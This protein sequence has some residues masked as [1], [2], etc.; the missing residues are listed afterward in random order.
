M[1]YNSVVYELLQAVR[2][3][4]RERQQR[5]VAE[6][7]STLLATKLF[8]PPVRPGLVFR[9]RLLDKLNAV[10]GSALTLVSAPAG[11][12]KTTLISEWVNSRH[13]PLPTAWLSL[14]ESE[15]D[16]ARFWEYFVAALRTVRPN[17]GEATLRQLHSL[18]P[19]PIESALAPLVNDLAVIVEDLVMVLD[20]YHFIE[21]AP[22]NRGVSFFLDH[23]PPRM[24]LII[25]TRVDPPLPLARLRGK[26]VLCEIGADDLRFTFEEAAVLLRTPLGPELSPG[27]LRAINARAEGWAVGLKMAGLSLGKRRDVKESVAAFAGSQRYVM[28]YLMDEV[29]RQQSAEIRSFLLMTSIL[30]RLCAP[31]CAAVTGRDDSQELLEELERSHLFVVPL[32][33]SRK[34]YRYEHL[35]A[36]LLKHRLAIE[37]GKDTAV[38]L[39]QKASRW[40]EENG[41]DESAI[42]CALAARDWK[43]A[44]D[45]VVA[46]TAPFKYGEATT[47]RWLGQIPQEVLVTNPQASLMYASTARQAG[48]MNVGMTLLDEYERAGSLSGLD[49]RAHR[50]RQDIAGRVAGRAPHRG[51]R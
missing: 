11:F 22:V 43:R 7:E 20:D 16:P 40:F 21:S 47:Y 39:Q 41:L 4:Y 48:G 12:G 18:Q 26:G 9:P 28:D 13:P 44:M 15:N 36:E 6:V 17:V 27:D 3:T 1:C 35:F 34:W 19:V 51:V 37:L 42:D 24:H 5:L 50:R 2:R 33:E 49:D 10:L 30:G 32:D 31:L 23:M 29:L 8:V 46:S 25:A 45:M 14:E 38:D